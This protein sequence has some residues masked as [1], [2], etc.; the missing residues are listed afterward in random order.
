MSSFYSI[1]FWL[2][3]Y[4]KT[5]FK[6]ITVHVIYSILISLYLSSL[7]AF[8]SY[9]EFPYRGGGPPPPSPTGRV[10]QCQRLEVL[11]VYSIIL[12]KLDFK[13]NS[14]EEENIST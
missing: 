14:T 12:P 10:G 9:H 8:I 1:A 13:L 5:I 7:V 11:V 6:G 2:L 3:L 4:E